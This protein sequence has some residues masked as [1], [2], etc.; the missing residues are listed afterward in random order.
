M[1][2]CGGPQDA[3]ELL[4]DLI[5]AVSEQLEA[6]QK[7][8]S[9]TPAP[10]QNGTAAAPAQPPPPRTWVHDL[11]QVRARPSSSRPGLLRGPRR[12]LAGHALRKEKALK[13]A[14]VRHC[15]KQIET[16]NGNFFL[17]WVRSWHCFAPSKQR[18]KKSQPRDFV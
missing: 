3:H 8:K 6:E 15:P 14:Y 9:P 11:F 13:L 17:L 12:A 5:N 2:S 18:R 7:A 1:R 4:L 10:Q 16:R